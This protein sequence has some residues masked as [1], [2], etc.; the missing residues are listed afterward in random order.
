MGQGSSVSK[1]D[2]ET[3]AE[4]LSEHTG[5]TVEE[6]RRLHGEYAAKNKI[7]KK[8]FLREFK[9]TFPK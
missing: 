9:K 4:Y 1:V 8:E 2:L 6:V 3:E 7:T 5:L